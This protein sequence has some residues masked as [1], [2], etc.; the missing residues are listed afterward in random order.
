MDLK[1]IILKR[2][3]VQGRSFQRV[4][5]VVDEKKQSILIETSYYVELLTNKNGT[6]TWGGK[7]CPRNDPMNRVV[8]S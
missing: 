1:R 5:T 6:D 3:M 8:R 7:D 2:T 4:E